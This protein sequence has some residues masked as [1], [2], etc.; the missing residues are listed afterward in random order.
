VN[1][2]AVG[3]GT[4]AAVAFVL[5]GILGISRALAPAECPPVLPYEPAPYR[6]AGSP[7]L[8]PTLSG[9]DDELVPAEGVSF[10]LAAWAVWVEPGR[11]PAAPG[12]PFPQRIVLECG[13]GTF[14]A[15]QRGTE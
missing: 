10:G 1:P 9:V 2:R 8:V 14:Q 12:D 13:D 5:V 7:T 4:V 6:P 3:C 15:Y 11:A